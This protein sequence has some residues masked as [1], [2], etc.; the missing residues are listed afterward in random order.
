M[1]S[2]LNV[3]PFFYPYLGSECLEVEGKKRKRSERQKEQ[4][5][6]LGVKSFVWSPCGVFFGA[7]SSLLRLNKL[8]L[9]INR[10]SD[11]IHA[12]NEKQ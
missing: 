3:K 12:P 11:N 1:G 2:S 10:R 5:P 7:Q 6:K 9:F 8:K 4:G